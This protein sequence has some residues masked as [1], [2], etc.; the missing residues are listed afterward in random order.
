MM[1]ITLRRQPE[2]RD[3][4]AYA[5]IS[6]RHKVHAYRDAGNPVV[7]L[8]WRV[9]LNEMH[10]YYGDYPFPRR[11][12]CRDCARILSMRRLRSVWRELNQE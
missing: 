8:C 4:I 12:L 1:R 11:D 5:A 9:A 6:P 7:T 10:L 2:L 3:R